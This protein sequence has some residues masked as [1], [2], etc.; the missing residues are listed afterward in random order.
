[1]CLEA[2]ET[3]YIWFAD[4]EAA[5]KHSRAHVPSVHPERLTQPSIKSYTQCRDKSRA[6]GRPPSS[7][8]R[9]KLYSKLEQK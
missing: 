6:K 1:M 9:S 4:I 5:T 7:R 3:R 8:P 2:E